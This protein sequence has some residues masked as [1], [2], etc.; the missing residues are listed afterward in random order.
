MGRGCRGGGGPGVGGV[1]G[2]GCP[3]VGGV[4]GGGGPVGGW[5][6]GWWGSRGVWVGKIGDWNILIWHIE[7]LPVCYIIDLEGG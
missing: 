4:G 2:G 3:G 6:G 1:G 5:V 7:S